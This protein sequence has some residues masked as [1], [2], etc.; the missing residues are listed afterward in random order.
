MS[1]LKLNA[2]LFKDNVIDF[3][4]YRNGNLYYSIREA[5]GVDYVFPVPITDTGDAV[6]G[7]SDRAILFMRWIRKAIENDEIHK[8]IKKQHGKLE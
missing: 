6:F 5:N 4:Y 7:R 8:L 3:Q 1:N 2:D